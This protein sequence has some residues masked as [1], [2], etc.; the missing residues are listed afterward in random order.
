MAERV[1]RAKQ[2][3]LGVVSALGSIYLG[4]SVYTYSKW[5]PSF[6]TYSNAPARN[7]G[8]IAGAYISDTLMTIA[9]YSVFTIPVFLLAY[10]IRRLMGKERRRVYL[11]GGLLLFFRR[12]FLYHSFVRPL[13]SKP[14][15]IRGGF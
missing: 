12:P 2:E 11:F 15:P 1:K 10:G 3:V 14:N 5:D 9:G 13:T 4:L 8:G 7:Y 6:F